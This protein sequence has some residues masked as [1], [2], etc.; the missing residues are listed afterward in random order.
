[1]RFLNFESDEFVMFD[2][3]RVGGWM[4]KEK[5]V[6]AADERWGL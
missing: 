5:E 3:S 1:M 6:E 4:L 2:L